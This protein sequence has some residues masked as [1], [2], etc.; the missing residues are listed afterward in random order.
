MHPLLPHP[1]Y[2]QTHC[3]QVLTWSTQSAVGELLG[4]GSLPGPD[5]HS[6]HPHGPPALQVSCRLGAVRAP[7]SGEPAAGHYE[8]ML[9]VG[10][11]I[12]AI[13]IMPSST[14]NNSELC[15]LFSMC[16]AQYFSVIAHPW[17]GGDC[18]A[19]YARRQIHSPCIVPRQHEE[20]FL[21]IGFCSGAAAPIA[22]AGKV[23][24]A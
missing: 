22:W 15:Y 17:R 13:A 6:R 11:Y 3:T 7:S 24:T 23:Q 1:A 2:T 9:V 19:P 8:W 4:R 12:G 5:P 21:F 10:P 16:I 20:L 14:W 18:V